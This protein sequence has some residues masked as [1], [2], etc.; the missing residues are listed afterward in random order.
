MKELKPIKITLG[1]ESD[2][3]LQAFAKAFSALIDLRWNCETLFQA[4]VCWAAM[5]IVEK[6]AEELD[7]VAIIDD[8]N[9]EVFVSYPG[10]A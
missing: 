10:C 3:K 8:T 6:L 9:R 1:D 7:L 4:G 5:D 2:E